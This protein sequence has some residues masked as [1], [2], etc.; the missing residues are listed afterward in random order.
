[1]PNVSTII[2]LS[3]DR[4]L[5]YYDVPQLFIAKDQMGLKY[6]SLYI[7]GDTP[8][9]EYITVPVSE[10]KLN[11]LVTGEID[12]RMAFQSSENGVW[13]I[14]TSDA[15]DQFVLNPISFDTVD[16]KYLPDSGFYFPAIDSDDNIII[17]EATEKNNAIVHL[18]FMDSENSNSIDVDLFG[19]MMKLFQNL[20]KYSYKKSIADIKDGYNLESEK[21]Y[22]L[23]AFATSEGSFNVHMQ[24]VANTDLFGNSNIEIALKRI[25]AII[26]DLDNESALI[27]KIKIIKGHAIGAYK[28]ILD[29]IIKHNFNLSY[30]WVSPGE[31]KV[32]K[33][34]I[35]KAYAERVKEIIDRKEELGTEL[36]EF[37]GTVNEID[38]VNMKWRILNNED[39]KNYSGKSEVDLAGIIIDSSYNFKCKE[40]LETEIATGKEKT[41]YILLEWS[42]IRI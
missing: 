10:S 15:T 31:N 26:G 35:N 39:A 24:S 1:M 12:L 7:G 3:V 5:I 32:H 4:I 13:Y 34:R 30:K 20:V 40:I 11:Q 6:V 2:R 16:E 19:D 33:K 41:S 22:Q 17:Q 28:N 23:K 27:E 8:F 9:A 38:S 14:M 42:P 36:R 37:S 18:T 25:D 21:N 29:K